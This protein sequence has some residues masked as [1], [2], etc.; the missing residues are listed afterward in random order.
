MKKHLPYFLFSAISLII[1]IVLSHLFDFSLSNTW[2]ASVALLFVFGPL[3]I[4]A[5]KQACTQKHRHPVICFI[6]RFYLILMLAGYFI[7]TLV[8]LFIGF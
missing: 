3:W 4:C 8:F 5:W 6:V 7:A 2:Q 1:S